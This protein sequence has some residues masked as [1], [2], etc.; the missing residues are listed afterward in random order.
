MV[1]LYR[2]CLLVNKVGCQLGAYMDKTTV[3][4]NLQASVYSYADM[5][6]FDALYQKRGV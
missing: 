4:S 3:M 6:V 2:W 5:F 1:A